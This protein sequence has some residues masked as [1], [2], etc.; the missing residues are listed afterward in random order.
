MAVM[1]VW[2]SAVGSVAQKDGTVIALAVFK[3]DILW[4]V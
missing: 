4:A 3:I 1:M 2:I